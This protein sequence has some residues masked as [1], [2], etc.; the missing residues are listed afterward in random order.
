METLD[1]LTENFE[2]EWVIREYLEL[3]LKLKNGKSYE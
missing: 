1:F 3:V 2:K